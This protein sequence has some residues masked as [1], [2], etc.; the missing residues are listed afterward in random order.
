MTPSHT[1]RGIDA[2]MRRAR[3]RPAA[4]RRD[5]EPSHLRLARLAVWLSVGAIVAGALITLLPRA[6][7]QPMTLAAR[8]AQAALDQAQAAGLLTGVQASIDALRAGQRAVAGGTRAGTGA[9][10]F[11]C[12]GLNGEGDASGGFPRL[13]GLPAFY[14]AKQMD[15]YANGSRNN[16][17]MT[18]IANAMS[19]DE[20]RAVAIYYAT[21]PVPAGRPVPADPAR[22]QQGANIAAVGSS[23]R[24]LQACSNCHGVAGSGMPP[25]VPPLAG[26]NPR[27]L[28]LQLALWQQG[29]RRNDVAGVMADV[30][31]RLS[32]DEQRA[33]AEYFGALPPR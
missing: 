15:D 10:C 32:P 18:P 2:L 22:V 30:A 1:G 26:Q 7:A 11:N 16:D 12:H 33:V 9:A 5:D 4:R 13:A 28:A 17:K 8:D 20:R 27:Y 29:T 24:G 3:A 19:V 6:W 25:D 21:L 14:L 23:A 31:R